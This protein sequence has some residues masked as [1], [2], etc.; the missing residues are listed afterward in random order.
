MVVANSLLAKKACVVAS[1]AYYLKYYLIW[2]ALA[3]FQ[4]AVYSMQ[5]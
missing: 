3:V 4:L 2:D 1:I 5:I